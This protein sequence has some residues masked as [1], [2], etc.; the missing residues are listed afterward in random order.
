MRLLAIGDNVCDV[1]L[2]LAEMFPGGQTMNVSVFAKMQGID[3]A[4]MGVFGDDEVAEHNQKTLDG[5]GVDYSHCRHE[6]GENGYACVTLVEGDRVFLGSNK[7]GV[8]REFPL[9]LTEEDIDYIRQFS[10]VH[11]SNNS[12][13]DGQ[14]ERLAATGVPVSYDFSNQW[15]G[16]R[17]WAEKLAPHC[18]F[19]FLS[20]PDDVTPEE[21]RGYCDWMHKCGCRKIVATNGSK[22]AYFYDGKN[23]W[24]QPSH[25]V[26]PLDTLGA[27][28]AYAATVLVN[29]YQSLEADPE[30]MEK[31]PVYYETEVKKALDTAA[32]F[33]SRVCLSRGAFDHG[34]KIDPDRYAQL[35]KGREKSAQAAEG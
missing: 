25:L 13:F 6:H 28:D 14:L 20:L 33:S 3:S 32:E 31:D 7:G 34:K 12:F 35:L 16:E 21:A 24:F 11:T 17:E 15:I 30:A 4:Y 10:V 8:A 1:Y 5:F 19:C 27:G 18:T 23:F 9:E 2:H 26:K 29:Y 22:G